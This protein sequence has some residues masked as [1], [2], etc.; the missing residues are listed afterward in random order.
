M[1]SVDNSD[2]LLLGIS[3]K[4]SVSMI[5]VDG[6]AILH[7]DNVNNFGAHVAVVEA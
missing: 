7:A 5:D 3:T 6:Q 4:A 1:I 2:A